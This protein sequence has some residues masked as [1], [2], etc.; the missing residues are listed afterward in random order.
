M[1]NEPVFRQLLRCFRH[2]VALYVV[3]RGA[4]P[5]GGLAKTSPYHA[6]AAR[7][8]HGE[9]QIDVF[10]LQIREALGQFQFQI[11]CRVA[12]HEFVQVW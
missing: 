6:V 1:G 10:L 11:N 7:H 9:D 5:I 4:K 2:A 3:R 12:A 8:R